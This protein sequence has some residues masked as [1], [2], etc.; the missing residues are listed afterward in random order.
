MNQNVA[1]ETNSMQLVEEF[2]HRSNKSV[3]LTGKAGT[4]KTT[5]LKK[6]I[7]ESYK[8]TAV[9]A[10][11]GIAALNADGVT[12]HSFFQLPFGGFIPEFQVD[13]LFVQDTR[14]ESK[15]TLMRNSKMNKKRRQLLRNLE[16]LVIDEVS[17]LRADLL[18]AMDWVLRNVRKINSPFGG[19]QVL[20]IGD[21]LQLPPVTRAE[22]WSVLSKYYPSMFFFNARVLQE[23]PP[24]Y[25]ELKHIYRQEDS[26]FIGILNELRNNTISDSSVNYLNQ[27]VK[28]QHEIDQ[29]DGFITLTTHNSKADAINRQMLEKLD[30]KLFEFEADINNDFPKT[31]F[32]LD[33][34]LLL[35]VGAQIMFIKNDSS[36]EKL[37]YN[38]KMGIVARLNK[39]E[40]FVRFEGE[41]NLVEVEKVEWE[42][43]RYTING[44]GEIEEE[45]IGTFF[46]Y[47]IKLA[48][49][50]TVHKSQGL[51]FDRAILDVGS[52][53]AP[54]QAYVAF[55]RLRSLQGLVLTKSIAHSG[56]N[57]DSAVMN[58][59]LF[60]QEHEASLPNQLKWASRH[61]LIDL[62][63]TSFDFD[64]LY[65]LWAQHSNSYV[66]VTTKSEK[67]KN[68][69]W[70]HLLMQQLDVI[71]SNAPKLRRQL[72]SILSQ[73]ELNESFLNERV[74]AAYGYFYKILDNIEYST[75]KKM[76]ELA[77]S[78][79]NK[80]YVEELEDLEELTVE[81]VLRIKKARI[82]IGA[83]CSGKEITKESVFCKEVKHYRISKLDL[84]KQE[85]QAVTQS[86]YDEPLRAVSTKAIPNSKKIKK[87]SKSFTLELLI[88]GNSIDDIVRKREL[89]RKS[90]Y[91]HFI[92]L[93]K[94]GEIEIEDVL[95]FDKIKSIAS[96]ICEHPG[97]PMYALFQEFGKG[98]EF[99]EFKLYNISLQN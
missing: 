17:M 60:H 41:K 36:P 1:E 85:K 33:E 19:V 26:D 83:F 15:D 30:S 74:Q 9:V 73:V 66:N 71:Q 34:T 48:W 89:S 35:K 8:Q 90:V 12:I 62:L 29:L 82:I 44:S 81:A 79:K 63:N 88:A 14:F 87:S 72:G 46:H 47:P 27:F 6:I 55:S 97:V 13:N 69:S 95:S 5:L 53:F 61:Y 51:T 18:D 10:P 31:I 54:G 70:I 7:R 75:L 20:F 3:F 22:E 39:H 77:R 91:Q 38:G 28:S 84:L 96:L 64:A 21:L 67:G 37:F 11:T 49:A 86:L 42:N 99:E 76:E 52:V 59:I 92:Q 32:P 80:L 78:A 50:I 58:F 94:E 93:L 56:L 65:S 16:L 45:V 57:N 40:I 98:F 4:G 2:I 25:I 24:F 43:I 68:K 23:F